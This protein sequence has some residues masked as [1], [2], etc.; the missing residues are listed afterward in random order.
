MPETPPQKPKRK[1]KPSPPPA[2]LGNNYAEGNFG[3][4]PTKYDPKYCK[5][6]V[7]FFKRALIKQYPIEEMQKQD[8]GTWKPVITGYEK[9]IE[10]MPTLNKFA[11]TIG[12]NEDTIV[13][14]A[15]AYPEFTAA[16]R[17][18]K[19]L[20][21]DWLVDNAANNRIPQNVFIFVAKNF[22]DMQD[23]TTVEDTRAYESLKALEEQVRKIAEGK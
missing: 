7:V 23:K 1:V 12:V 20:M 4:A 13:E 2:P 11:M 6:I 3:G 5:E 14:W 9:R 16:Y 8:D 21:R 17:M 22:T 19:Y 10:G 18:S 15:K